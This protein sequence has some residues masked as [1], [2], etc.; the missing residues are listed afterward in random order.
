MRA[1]ALTDHGVLH[2]AVKFYSEAM[3]H[4]IK[5]LIG[6]EVYVAA[7]GLDAKRQRGSEAT[8]H[9]TLLAENQ[10]G[11]PQSLCFVVFGISEGFLLPSQDRP[12]DHAVR[13]ISTGIGQPR[14]RSNTEIPR[15]A[16]FCGGAAPR[17]RAAR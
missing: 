17:S 5:P 16:C 13:P 9:L 6:C 3:A 15:S 7:H 2:G 4:G 12:G 8:Y 10:E 1:I 14:A 11:L